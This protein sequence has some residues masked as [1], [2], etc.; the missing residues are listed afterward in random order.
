MLK[1]LL[2][3]LLPKRLIRYDDSFFEHQWYESWRELKFTLF[4]LINSNSGW[5]K[6]MDFGCGPG[7]MIDFM[8]GK[9]TIYIG[10]DFSEDARKLYL[11]KFGLHPEL[12]VNS[13]DEVVCR[14][15]LDVFLSFDVFEHMT[16]LQ[17]KETLKKIGSIPTLFLNISRVRGIPGHVNI[18]S[19]RG[20]IKFIKNQ[21]YDFAKEETE[22]I[23]SLYTRLRPEGDDGWE[24]NMFIFHKMKKHIM[25]RQF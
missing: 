10:C 5:K 23:R 18:K 21:G 15:E 24:K 11:E 22:K 20:W 2:Q 17:I 12:Y 13:L 4:Q 6:I 8:Y 14:Q 19:E 16:D 25:D 1:K 7:V 9:S 3:K